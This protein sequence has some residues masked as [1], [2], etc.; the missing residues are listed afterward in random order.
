M[1]IHGTEDWI[2]PCDEGKLIYKNLPE[3][4]EKKL[5]LIDGAGHNNIF[6]FKEEY[7]TPLKEF[8]EKHKN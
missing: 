6:S 4:V 3:D 2:I 5:V 1:I 8:I 7:T